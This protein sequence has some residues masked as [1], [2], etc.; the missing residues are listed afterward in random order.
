MRIDWEDLPG[1]LDTWPRACAQI[2]ADVTKEA[3]AVFTAHDVGYYLDLDTGQ[4][5]VHADGLIDSPDRCEKM[6]A[7]LVRC[8]KAAAR[9]VGP[10]QVN[11]SFIALADLGSPDRALVKIAYSKTLRG[12][13]EGLNFFPGHYPGGIPNQASPL[14]AMLTTGILG[15]G[16]GWGTGKL[17]GA[18]APKRF[19]HNLGRTGLLLGA[20]LG[21]L[22]GAVWMGRNLA[23]DKSVL[24]PYPYPQLPADGV[25]LGEHYTAMV[26][27]FL[28]DF[29]EAA[30]KE[31]AAAFEEWAPARLATPADVN[32]NALGRTLW[33]AGASPQLAGAALGTMYAASLLPDPLAQPGVATGSQI[34]QLAASMGGSYVKGLLAGAALNAVVGTPYPASTYGLGSM[35]LGVVG[36]VLP[37]IF[38]G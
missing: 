2:A 14:A 18:L 23:Q 20:G 33:G 11:G 5:G 3:A 26:T 4:V 15:A 13:A 38:G 9:A 32:I 8:S 16:L 34:G 24:D 17:L 25:K 12:L 27:G 10:E 36:S 31:A 28:H 22:P 30:E 19:G 29:Q 7:D 21:A 37:K 1:A 6:A 35:A